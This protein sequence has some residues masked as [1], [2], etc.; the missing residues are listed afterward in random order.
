M[1]TGPRGVI[2]Q[3]ARSLAAM[4]PKH[5]PGAAQTLHHF[6]VVASAQGRQVKQKPVASQHVKIVSK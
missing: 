2:L 1:E 4:E 6:T 3:V 5:S